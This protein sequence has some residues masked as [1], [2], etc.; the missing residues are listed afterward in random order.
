MLNSVSGRTVFLLLLLFLSM[1]FG[2][3]PVTNIILLLI[4]L[5]N[6]LGLKLQQWKKGV[7]S[8]IFIVS[9]AFYLLSLLS[10]L[11]T[12]NVEQGLLQLETK[13][14]FL[15]APLV[16][17]AS[18][19][20]EVSKKKDSI[21]K[22]FIGG[23]IAVGLAALGIA[24]LNTIKT[25][26]T[27]FLGSDGLTQISFFTYE[28]LAKP[29][30]HPGYLSMY[31][32]MAIIISLYFLLKEK[33]NTR[34]VYTIL[35]AFLF[36][37]MV[38]LQGRIN[39]LALLMVLGLGALIMAIKQKAY[40]I[41]FLPLIPGVLLLGFVAFGSESIKARYLQIPDFSYDISGN[42]FNSATYRL[43]E[44]KCAS[45]VIAEQPWLGTGVGANWEALFESYENNKFWAGLERKF[46]AHNQYVETT[47]TIGYVGLMILLLMLFIYGKIALANK[48][49]LT[50]ACLAFFA[51]SMLTESM[52]ERS[53][54]VL[55]FTSFFPL[56]LSMR[57]SAEKG[58]SD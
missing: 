22:A 17:V 48:D 39:M 7:Q 45:D 32:G 13:F 44:W 29:F 51:I 14:T 15:L 42:D 30:M 5:N 20:D 19:S 18:T 52:L 34:V 23:N 10:L 35:I 50:L 12:T 26:N 38:L 21:L 24:L 37:V 43:A 49:Y 36:V 31:V 53:A 1:P 46:N 16:L 40:K 27:Y 55:L 2:I 56:M 28:Q 58:D 47:I 4:L 57:P 9:A 54:A 25:G 8:N 6:L 33:G 41:L 11:W 3:G